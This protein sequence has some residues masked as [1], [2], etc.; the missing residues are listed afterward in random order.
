[1]R[2]AAPCGYTWAM[3]RLCLIHANCQGEP[4]VDLLGAHP[5][6]SR[7]FETRHIVN[8]TRQPVPAEDL[9]RCGL[10]L[11]Q[12]L[13]AAWGDLASDALLA[14]LPPGTRRLC[15]PNLF[16]LGYWP[17]WTGKKGFDYSDIFLDALLDR[18]LS[19]REIMHLYLRTDPTRYYDLAAIF[20]KSETRER[21]KERHWDIRLTDFVRSRFREK[22]LFHTVNHPGRTLCLMVAEAVLM[23][24]GYPPLP[25][26][27]REAFAD[28]FAEFDL[29]I[30]PGVAAFQGLAFLPEHPRFPV[31]G[32][33]MDLAEYVGCY[34]ACKRLGETDFISFLR[35]RAA[36]CG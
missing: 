7:D 15:L 3:K 9:A 2:A 27:A 24:L 1:M 12:R 23:R 26:G 4:L 33:D 34:L 14:R 30:H 28:P 32:R 22:P 5:D 19:D 11:Y 17:F 18:G 36:L 8:Y 10:F 20:R 6:F 16:F 31:Y 35:L 29:P 21:E 13:E 25:A